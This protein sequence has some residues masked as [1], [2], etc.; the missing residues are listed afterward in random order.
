LLV[1]QGE[2]PEV[3]GGAAFPVDTGDDV[4]R[5]APV[6]EVVE[7]RE[8]A[9]DVEG[10][11]ER[12]VVGDQK[13]DVLAPSCCVSSEDRVVPTEDTT[14]HVRLARKGAAREQVIQLASLGD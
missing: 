8:L 1:G 10:V 14:E 12:R 9:G 4:D 11:L 5:C 6:A 2:A 13:P 7:R 3:L